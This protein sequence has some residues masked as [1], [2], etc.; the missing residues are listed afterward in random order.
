M[1]LGSQAF[2]KA[3]AFNAN[4]GAWN[5]A[6]MTRLQ[7]VCA[8]CHRLCAACVPWLGMRRCVACMP[9]GRSRQPCMLSAVLHSFICASLICR[10][11][12]AYSVVS[13]LSESAWFGAKA[14]R[15]AT[16]FNA[17]IGAWN[18]ASMTTMSYVCAVCH[19]QRVR[20]VWLG[21]RRG[22]ALRCLDAVG[23]G[24]QPC[25][26]S[27]SLILLC[28]THFLRILRILRSTEAL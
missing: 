3:A 19:R 9:F 28:C 1:W 27:A 25:M 22:A 16:V 13:K 14:F 21:L 20:P 5:T 24:R 7:A 6:R 15:G 23:R 26:L 10:V 18:T 11:Y 17:N 12:L 8:N 2:M 4:I